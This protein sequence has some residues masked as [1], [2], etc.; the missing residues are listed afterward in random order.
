MMQG[1]FFL[2]GIIGDTEVLS[3]KS[4][5]KLLKPHLIDQIKTSTSTISNKSLFPITFIIEFNC[6]RKMENS[7]E[8]KAH[9]LTFANK[10][11]E[12][13]KNPYFHTLNAR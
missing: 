11:D 6:K 1:Y 13:W 8:L 4:Q 5:T 10:C 2:E 12:K 7:T 3:S 9:W